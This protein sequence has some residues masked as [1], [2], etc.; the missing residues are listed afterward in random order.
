MKRLD[1]MFNQAT[2]QKSKRS[3]KNVLPFPKTT[4]PL[5]SF[6][7]VGVRLTVSGKGTLPSKVKRYLKES[8]KSLHGVVLNDS[9]AHYWINVVCLMDN[10]KG[11]NLSYFVAGTI[12]ELREELLQAPDEL[13]TDMMFDL[14]DGLCCML[15]HRIKVGPPEN[16]KIA[17]EKIVSEFDQDYLQE[18]RDIWETISDVSF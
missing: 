16:L 14:F 13:V 7:K 4:K 3:S 9:D 8:L 12:P 2:R 11:Y 18:F 17:C 15:E 6:P 10:L 5:E 1:R